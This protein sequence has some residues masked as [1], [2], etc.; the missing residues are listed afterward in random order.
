MAGSIERLGGMG[1][2]IE[3]AVNFPTQI[4]M[5]I[6]DGIS[7]PGTIRPLEYEQDPSTGRYLRVGFDPGTMVPRP[8]VVE[9]TPFVKATIGA[10]YT[11][12]GRVYL[13]VQYVHGFI[14]EFGAGRAARPRVNPIDVKE[15]PR[16]ES[17]LGDY[18]VAGVD[19]KTLHDR[20][21]LRFFGVLKLP[22]VDL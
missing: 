7:V 9:S 21:L 18:I 15:S 1:Y 8:V 17:R 11:I 16:V 12:A 14:D 22:S 6:Y 20:L 10:D 2:W 5:G 13:N 4:T 3:A 19:I